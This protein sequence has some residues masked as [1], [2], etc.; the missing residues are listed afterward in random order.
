MKQDSFWL[1]YSPSDR[2]AVQHFI[3]SEE[4]DVHIHTMEDGSVVFG[5]REPLDMMHF[6]LAST[7]APHLLRE[8]PPG[9]TA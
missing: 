5:F 9:L 7:G 6:W 8:P 3:G 1:L 2:G 4:P